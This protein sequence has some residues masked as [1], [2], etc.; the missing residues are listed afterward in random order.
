MRALQILYKFTKLSLVGLPVMGSLLLGGCSSDTP[1]LIESP[2]EPQVEEPSYTIALQLTTDG[3]FTRA[4]DKWEDDYVKDDGTAFDK[5]IKSVDLFLVG[6][7]NKLTPLYALEKPGSAAHIYTCQ[8]TDKTPGVTIDKK[9]Q[10]GIFQGKIMALANVWDMSVPWTDQTDWYTKK[11]PFK[12][13]F[14]TGNEW[15]IPMW[16]IE[17][18]RADLKANEMTDLTASPVYLLRAVSKIVV[19]L[20][21]S[22]T[23]D[24]EI[25]S[26]TMADGSPKMSGSGYG[27]PGNDP[28]ALASTKSLKIQDSFNPQSGALAM[29]QLNWKIDDAK[30]EA[31]TYIAESETTY[32]KPFRLAVSLLSK[33]EVTP[34]FNGTLYFSSYNTPDPSR[35]GN[36]ITK[37]V[38][39]H[40]YVFT[41]NLAKM[42]LL[43]TVKQWELG[44]K[45]HIDM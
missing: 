29:D 14:N 36:A 15:Y 11:L 40:E 9:N 12:V 44:G 35:P 7:D 26:I 5:T 30:K 18:Y 24:Y 6:E 27:L 17:S 23:K 33:N 16:G 41:I 45:V 8:V 28:L 37:V 38:R 20:D 34:V 3:I 22:I 2:Q 31:V 1:E 25:G 39:N 13:K 43:T 10:T 32:D 21:D 19:K 4:D 42:E